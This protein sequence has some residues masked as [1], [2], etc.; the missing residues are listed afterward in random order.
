MDTQKL[1]QTRIK[2]EVRLQL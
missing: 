2:N 1:T